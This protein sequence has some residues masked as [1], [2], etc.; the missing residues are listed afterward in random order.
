VD[1]GGSGGAPSGYSSS[2]SSPSRQT[3]LGGR[4]CTLRGPD[5]RSAHNSQ[6]LQQGTMVVA[7]LRA[8]GSPASG[9]Q[10]RARGRG[11]ALEE[12]VCGRAA[13]W[14]GQGWLTGHVCYL[15]VR[16]AAVE[17]V[18]AEHDHALVVQALHDAVAYRGLAGSGAACGT[19]LAGQ[20]VVRGDSLQTCAACQVQARERYCGSAG[21]T[22]AP[23]RLS[24]W[25]VTQA[26][27]TLLQALN[28]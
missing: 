20:A 6:R 22:V 3:R 5:R 7:S 14:G 13:L 26:A 8:T 23:Q 17:A 9:A 16:Q 15:G 10:G 27:P 12:H 19:T 4:S 28:R 24:A 2:P 21:D 18:L 1:R 25:F 11:S